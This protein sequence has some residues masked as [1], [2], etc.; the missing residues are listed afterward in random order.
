MSDRE[1]ARVLGFEVA[2]RVY[3]LPIEAV[4]E[5]AELSSA[6]CVPTLPEESVAVANWNGEAL[7]MV[8]PCLLLAPR[9]AS[10]SS[11][12]S[13]GVWREVDQIV[14]LVMEGDDVPWLGLPVET[15]HEVVSASEPADDRGEGV[16]RLQD[17]R[18]VNLLVPDQ[19]AE[20]A[21]RVIDE[22]AA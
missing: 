5:V 4:L 9:D 14:V 1:P 3:G 12:T 21:Q 10:P 7:P 22:L 20:Q 19:L 8:A 2:G 17:G 15:V 6:S 13:D 18:P 11:P 16:F